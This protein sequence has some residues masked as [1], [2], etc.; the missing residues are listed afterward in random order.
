MALFCLLFLTGFSAQ[1]QTTF[2]TP[3]TTGPTGDLSGNT[4]GGNS[5][6]RPIVD[7]FTGAPTGGISGLGPVN[8]SVLEFQ[9]S[10]SG[11]YTISS[12]QF[13]DGYLLLYVNSFDP[14]NQLTNLIIGD[15]DGP[16]G[17]GSSEIA[18]TFL[19]T[20]TT[21]FLVTTGFEAGDD[22]AFAN[23]ITG[24]GDALCVGS[25]SGG[26][27][28]GG[29]VTCTD[30]EVTLS[31]TLDNFPSETSW[32]LVD[33]V[34]NVIASS[35]SYFGRGG[36][37]VTEDFCLPDGCYS[38]RMFDSFG[39][40]ICCSFGNG[41]YS[42]EDASGTV[43]A[44][45]G[46]FDAEDITDFKLNVATCPTNT[47]MPPFGPCDLFGSTTNG[48]TWD[49]PIGTGPGI[50]SLGPVSYNALTFQVDVSG[51]YLIG[52]L[53]NYDGYIHV[54]INSFDP[55][56]QLTNLIAGNDDGIFG[57]GSSD[58][59]LFLN[60]GTE[61]IVVTSGFSLFDFGSFQTFIEGQ[62]G[63]PAE[64]A[65]PA[66]PL[67]QRYACQIETFDDMDPNA[68][69]M[70]M[71]GDPT[72][73]GDPAG[74]Y[75]FDAEGGFL[76]EYS[77]GSA[78]ITGR[79]THVNDPTKKVV[80]NVWL[81]NNANWAEWDALG[82]TW[83]GDASIVGNNFTNWSFWELDATRS[84]VMGDPSGAFA[85]MNFG[86]THKPANLMMGFQA[87]TAAND[88]NG[89]QGMSGWFFYSNAA[90]TRSGNGDFNTSYVSCNPRNAAPVVSPMMA[91]VVPNTA[92]SGDLSVNVTDRE[93]DALSFQLINIAGTAANAESAAKAGSGPLHGTVVLNS[94]GTYTY[95]PDAGYIGTDHFTF[96][97]H[98]NGASA[99]SAIGSINVQVGGTKLPVELMY[100]EGEKMDDRKVL[101]TWETATEKNNDYFVVEKSSDAKKFV[102]IGRVE[103]QGTT[104]NATAYEYTD[105]SP[106][107]RN[108]YYRLKQKDFDGEFSYSN[109]VE[110]RFAESAK[111]NVYP[112]P[113]STQLTATAA[114]P[115]VWVQAPPAATGSAGS[116]CVAGAAS[117]RSA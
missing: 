83:K 77:D 84:M 108:N 76:T 23:T 113:V 100:F 12:T 4:S 14:N 110:I 78:N 56:N 62:P 16:T 36:Q 5:W 30:N 103:G 115:E 22:G 20:G 28:G 33:G 39:D 64:N 74:R 95:T 94:N 9:V 51:T 3:C 96:T 53:Q 92:F 2:N 93:G 7:F 59:V 37:T 17:V 69:A 116:G 49:R 54:Y 25:G 105:A 73:A 102:P 47:S 45:G 82:R 79:M 50:S 99:A 32:E 34:G 81:I 85:G 87:G 11:S 19:N 88:K 91:G 40:G 18:G 71:S 97:V 104:G 90:G 117:W 57:V 101:L 24:P 98:Q 41:S 48:P 72:R 86:L 15:D 8:Y 70:I 109:I 10:T 31:I 60:A 21:Y 52:S 112:N 38:F 43:L 6:A 111:L 27:G 66:C 61:Y 42:L 89:D 35:P 107:S 106:M 44:S 1:A 65:T 68:W 26:G 46:D 67:A 29:P 80:V 58:V 114:L 75:L 55:E 63:T 13:F